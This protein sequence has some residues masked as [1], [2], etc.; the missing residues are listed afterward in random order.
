MPRVQELVS[1]LK[2]YSNQKGVRSLSD[3][4]PLASIVKELKDINDWPANVTNI[5]NALVPL[6][7]QGGGQGQEVVDN[8][9]S[10]LLSLIGNANAQAGLI[11]VN[12]QTTDLTNIQ[13]Q[14]QQQQQQLQLQL[15]EQEQF[16]IQFQQQQQQQQQFQIQLQAILAFLKKQHKRDFCKHFDKK[17][18]DC[19]GKKHDDHDDH[20]NNN[21]KKH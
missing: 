3:K 19:H 7:D 1:Q 18:H 15:Q 5:F 17:H 12:V 21:G 10:A 11:N 4:A 20:D 9:I 2:Q 6:I 8:L 13:Q 16:Q 14:Q